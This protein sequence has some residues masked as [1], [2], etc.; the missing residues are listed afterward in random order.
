MNRTERK[1]LER[2]RGDRLG[3]VPSYVV[4][5][6]KDGQITSACMNNAGPK[7]T[8]SFNKKHHEGSKGLVSVRRG[9]W[10]WS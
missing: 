8:M 5:I 7:R 10:I 1:W 6:L 3:H 2:D 4:R 9:L